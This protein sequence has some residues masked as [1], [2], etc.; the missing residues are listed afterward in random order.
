MTW[1]IRPEDTGVETVDFVF[2]FNHFFDNVPPSVPVTLLDEA[3][4][5]GRTFDRLIAEERH[6]FV[7]MALRIR[8]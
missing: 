5:A 1:S 6:R 3:A 2:T 7:S 8:W 4:S